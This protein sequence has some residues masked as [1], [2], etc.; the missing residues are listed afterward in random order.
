MTPLLPQAHF[1]CGTP[2]VTSTG[3]VYDDHHINL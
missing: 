3:V 1:I 2:R